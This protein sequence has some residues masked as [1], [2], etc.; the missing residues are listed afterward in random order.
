MEPQVLAVEKSVGEF[1]WVLILFF[2]I[3]T[4]VDQTQVS[5]SDT[6]C[7]EMGWTGNRMDEG[8]TWNTKLKVCLECMWMVGWRW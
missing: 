7:G 5:R 8:E 3:G 1:R 2:R 6:S 4:C